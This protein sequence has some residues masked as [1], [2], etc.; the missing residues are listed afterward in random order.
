MGKEVKS[1]A[2]KDRINKYDQQ[3][4]RKLVELG[5]SN[6]EYR[7]ILQYL[8]GEIK[9]STTMCK[10]DYSLMCFKNDG[11]YQLNKAIEEIYGV[12]QSKSESTPSGDDAKIQTVD[13]QL[14]DGTRLKVPYGKIDLPEAGKGANIDINYSNSNNTLII[15]GCCEYRFSSMID[16]IVERTQILLNSNSIYKNQAIELSDNCVPK[17]MDL[18]D[19]DKEFMVLS[20]RTEYDL[21]PLNSRLLHPDR[22]IEK[23]ISLKYG[24]LMEG[25]YG[26][27]KTLLA[28]KLAKNAIDNGW[29]FMYLK[30]PELLA[31]TLRLAK[32]L[33]KNG[34]GVVIFVED[35]DQVTRGN[36]DTAMQ[37]IL[38][39]LD[40]GD[41]K[42]M[43]VI[44]LFTTN[45]I[46][47]IEPTFLRGKRI[48]SIISLGFLDA[49]TAEKFVNETFSKDGY[50]VD[51]EG[52]D[53]VYKLIEKSDIAPAFMA[54]ITESVKSHMILTDENI[55][56]AEYLRNSVKSYLHQV[57]LS[58]KK[59]MSE[60]D[61]SKLAASMRSI[62]TSEL[63]PIMER[64]DQYFQD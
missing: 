63:K 59:D 38:N 60:T 57:V 19:I 8:E 37:D 40:G 1:V 34:H 3:M 36:R 13:I 27:G 62:I 50:V 9:Q 18:S 24:C 48:G 39:T 30:S 31:Q 46:E 28:F 17:I 47:L 29:V 11:V 54:E 44:S 2:V 58:R 22:C 32:T 52:I 14:A 21:Q 12:S 4:K 6:K 56:K 43:N 51:K 41:T 5:Q 25:P 7:H 20:S 16:D 45:H 26:T 35:I 49:V 64:V 42:Q 53:E 33:D 61:E 10:F 15:Q 55:V 23:G